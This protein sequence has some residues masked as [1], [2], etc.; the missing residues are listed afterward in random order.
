[1]GASLTTE[2]E[3]MT[4]VAVALAQFS[5]KRCDKEHNIGVMKAWVER[6]R[7]LGADL[8]IFPELSLTGYACRDLFYN[9]AEPIDGPSVKAL[10]RVARDNGVHIVFG[11]PEQAN[12][13]GVI[14]NTCVLTGPE[15]VLAHYRKMHLP[16]ATVF[17]EKRYFRQGYEPKVVSTPIGR[18]G[19]TICYDL[20]FPEVV[21]VLVMEGAELVICISVSPGVRKDYFETFTKARA[22]EN[23]VF[24]AYVN[25]VGIED[26]LQFWGGSHLLNPNGEVLAKAKYDLEDLVVG[27]VDY[28]DLRRVRTFLPT[29]RDLRPD[30][31]KRL[32]EAAKV[33]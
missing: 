7:G 25:R 5:P 10:E 27:N 23:S 13:Q 28:G 8:V 12:A 26:G 2:R 16:T 32:Y 9:L 4:K 14:Y 3:E 22:M 15:G 1:M 33:L 17:E 30:L 6:A 21:R 18:I 31:Y 20:F 19:L 24:L 11:M 29:L